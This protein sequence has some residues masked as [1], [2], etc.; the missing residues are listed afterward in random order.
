MYEMLILKL[1]H[2]YPLSSEDK[3]GLRA[4]CQGRPRHVGAR[5]QISSHSSSHDTILVLLRGWVCP[6]KHLSD[7]RWQILSFQVPGDYFDCEFQLGGEG[8]YALRTVTDSIVLELPRKQLEHATMVY[9]GLAKAFRRCELVQAAVL[10][11][12]VLSLGQR[13]AKERCAHLICEL[14]WRLRAVELTQSDVMDFPL[15]QE[16]VAGA[17]GVST[18]HANR[19]LQDL[20]GAGLIEQHGKKLKILDLGRLEAV[21]LFT[22]HFLNLDHGIRDFDDGVPRDLRRDYP[23][24]LRRPRMVNGEPAGRVRPSLSAG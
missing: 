14:F 10:R 6:Y 24:A 4:V 11:E 1:A 23:S 19:V 15:T 22:P 18:V 9:P 5:Q 7:G 2:F 12:W 16:E 21:A 8:D 20:R 3:A 13:N 17:I